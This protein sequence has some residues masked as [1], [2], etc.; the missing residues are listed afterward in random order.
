MPTHSIH[1][2]ARRH[3]PHCIVFCLTLAALS[4]CPARGS[5]APASALPTIHSA[6][7][8]SHF[9][10][11]PGIMRMVCARSRR[12]WLA[13]RWVA[14]PRDPVAKSGQAC[15]RRYQTGQA[16]CLQ[17]RNQPSFQGF[18]VVVCTVHDH[19]HINCHAQQMETTHLASRGWKLTR[20]AAQL[21][22][23]NHNMPP[24]YA[25]ACRRVT[26]RSGQD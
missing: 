21:Q 7:P 3:L 1:V 11:A 4:R 19:N 14:K 24:A 12:L 6:Q 26:Y 22:P 5:L 23:Q 17:V 8:T 16:L 10:C 15:G 18:R 13:Q 25:G 20:V 9:L 2:Q